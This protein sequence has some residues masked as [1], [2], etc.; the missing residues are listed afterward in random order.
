[1]IRTYTELIS[2]DSYLDRFEYLKLCGKVGEI[3]FGGHRYLNQAFY[4][5]KMW[6]DFKR[7]VIIRDNGCDMAYK[8]KPF[9][10]HERI[11]IHHLNPLKIE[12]VIYQTE[13]LMDFENVVA[14][15]FDTHQAIHY[16]DKSLLPINTFVIRRPNDT[17]PWR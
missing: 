15:S 8:D 9:Q 10:G 1:M 2:I 6:K 17:I 12:D 5:S 3:T 14:V 16:G 11:I 13:L 4:N 7:E